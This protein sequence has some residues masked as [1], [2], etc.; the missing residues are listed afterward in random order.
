[1]KMKA[2]TPKPNTEMVNARM[3]DQA[4]SWQEKGVHKDGGY[5]PMPATYLNKGY[6]AD[7]MPPEMDSS[8]DPFGGGLK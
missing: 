4:P 3:A 8:Y 1:M 5:C 6:W 2:L 7:E